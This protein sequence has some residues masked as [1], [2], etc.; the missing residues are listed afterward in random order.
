MNHTDAE[1]PHPTQPMGSLL[2]EQ[3]RATLLQV[4]QVVI[5]SDVI[6]VFA[7]GETYYTL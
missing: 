1:S 7:S 6:C 5:L 3:W 4:G 2:S